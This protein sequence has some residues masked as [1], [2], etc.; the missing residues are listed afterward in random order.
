MRRARSP[1]E[2]RDRKAG[3]PDFI[4]ATATLAFAALAGCTVGPDYVKPPMP[5]PAA[6]KETAPTNTADWKAARPADAIPRGAWWSVFNDPDLDALESQVDVAN[7]SLAQAEAQY[8]Q[9]AAAVGGARAG[10]APTIAADG[11]A[12][13]S[14][15]FSHA[16]GSQPAQGTAAS[17][18]PSNTFSLP[19][20]ASWEPDLW[21]RVRRT[22]EADTANAQ[23]SAALLESVRL[24]LHA[25]LAQDYF[26]LRSIDAQK[27]LLDDTVAGYQRSL[28]VTQNQYEAGVA[29]RADVVQAQAQLKSAQA[30]AIDLGVS[31]AQLE[32]AIA[33][34]VGKAPAE[35][36]IA[37][38]PLAA[39]PPAIPEGVPSELLERRPDVAQAERAM[40]AANAQVGIARAAYFPNL[41]L[42]ASGGFDSPTLGKWLRAES[43]FW[44]I[45][46]SLAA[47]LFDGG[48]RTSQ[49]RGA[50][51]GYDAAVANYR[52]VSLAA[53]QNVEDELAAVRIHA[54]EAA[55]QDEAVKVSG[56]A[57]RIATNQYRAGIVSY[58]NVV[59]AQNAAYANERAA[60]ALRGNRL[61]DTVLLIK[62]LGGG[63]EAGELPTHADVRRDAAGS[64]GSTQR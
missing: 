20:S 55:V 62:A 36:A 52:E 27:K 29:A 30:Q 51:A 54:Q 39:V 18:H 48:Q 50:R 38:K 60:I 26:Q 47:T 45:G 49:L 53:L 12:T 8:R 37:V 59:V 63:W 6:Y 46:A 35:V 3:V 1:D 33:L 13:R 57:L 17:S 4:R 44:S 34:L 32:H 11:S 9:A 25:E 41:T 10:Y 56:D 15:R 2:I 31:R 21:G 40:Q 14:G 42:S 7:Q 5:V 58:L 23:A 22:V 61:V 64:N 19:L 28:Q 43:G 16:A 24:S